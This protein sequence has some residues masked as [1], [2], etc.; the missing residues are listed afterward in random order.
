MATTVYRSQLRAGWIV[1]CDI[2]APFRIDRAKLATVHGHCRERLV[3]IEP[4]PIALSADCIGREGDIPLVVDEI[5]RSSPA[6]EILL[7]LSN[8]S[9]LVVPLSLIRALADL[10]SMD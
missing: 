8:D 10:P 7:G 5:Q 4:A 6:D 2:K 1:E 9:W 3:E